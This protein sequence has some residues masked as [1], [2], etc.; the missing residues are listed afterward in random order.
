ME[1]YWLGVADATTIYNE[2]FYRN[3]RKVRLQEISRNEFEEEY[4]R[5]RSEYSVNIM[6]IIDRERQRE[7]ARS[8][9]RTQLD[10]P[11]DTLLLKEYEHT[12]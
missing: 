3:L 6:I 9:N 7:Y 12:K 8:R 4:E 5:I 10:L 1:N 2:D 11:F